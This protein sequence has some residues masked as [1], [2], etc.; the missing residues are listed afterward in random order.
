[1]RGTLHILET[2]RAESGNP[3]TIIIRGV[4]GDHNGA[5]RSFRNIKTSDILAVEIN[6]TDMLSGVV[7][8]LEKVGVDSDMFSRV[9]L[10]GHGSEEGFTVSFVERIKSN[11]DEWRSKKGMMDLMRVLNPK[12]LILLSCHPLRRE[13][14]SNPLA[15]DEKGPQRRQGTASAIS[16]AFPV[17]VKSGLAGM[18]RA[19]ISEDGK[20]IIETE[21][22]DNGHR[23]DVMAL[24]RYGITYSYERG[25]TSNE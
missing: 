10:F 23:S 3:A 15:T 12:F 4:T 22:E 11:P 8:R 20:I 9:V 5:A 17:T 7:E 24:T 21:D 18:T 19:Y 16:S 1:M 25:E 2:G 13:N 14:G 6:H